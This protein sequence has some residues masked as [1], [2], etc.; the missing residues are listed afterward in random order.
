MTNTPTRT[1]TPILDQLRR[2]VRAHP[3]DPAV[4]YSLAVILMDPAEPRR[5]NKQRRQRARELL[6]RAVN[7][8]RDFAA[9]HALLAYVLLGFDDLRGALASLRRAV[10]LCP[11]NEIYQ[12][13]L[14]EALDRA[15]SVC[16]LQQ[17]LERAAK[18]RRI[19]L[20]SLRAQLREAKLPTRASTVRENAFPAGQRH[21]VSSLAEAVET[22]E[23]QYA[24]DV[25]SDAELADAARREVRIDARRVPADLRSVVHLA[26][27]W[28]I[29]D[30][31][32]RGLLIRRA[33]AAEK[34]E[35]RKTL[36][37]RLR[38]RINEWLDSFPDAS[39]MTREASHFMF[40]LEA[41]DEM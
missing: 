1:A 22:I 35:M 19:D 26:R 3:E 38:R 7:L 17:E 9:A 36:S 8:R 25:A 15:G 37:L 29:S 39:S 12:D 21:F 11:N 32:D 23:S 30:D 40:L 20:S 34:T 18:K 14:L 24:A 13:F 2:E 33:S 16:A 31:A 10:D 27:K 5:P 4:L 6:S 41:Y 28:G